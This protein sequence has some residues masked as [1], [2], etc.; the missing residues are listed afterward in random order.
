MPSAT[1]LP[2]DRPWYLTSIWP[3]VLAIPALTIVAGLSTVFIANYHADPLIEGSERPDI[4]AAHASP[5]ADAV[6]R[7]RR[8]AGTFSVDGQ[9]VTVELEGEGALPATLTLV[10]AHATR[11]TYDQ[12]LRA[13]QVAP[14][15]YRARV[16]DLPPGRWYAEVAPD[17]RAWRL[18]GRFGEGT[19]RA[20]LAPFV[21]PR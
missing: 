12:V 17:D 20:A 7:T 8:L 19:P 1:A 14:G 13:E 6:A 10:L 21:A 3:L 11:E 16:P 15:T 9:N 4:A 5:A 18:T 2:A